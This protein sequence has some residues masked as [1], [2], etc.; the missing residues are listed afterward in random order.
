MSREHTGCAGIVDGVAGDMK[1]ERFGQVAR[2]RG[3]IHRNDPQA[4]VP[5][6]KVFAFIAK[7]GDPMPIR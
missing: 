7:I 1:I 2:W 4:G 3:T 6:L 5:P